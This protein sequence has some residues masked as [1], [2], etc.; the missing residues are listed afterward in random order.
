MGE[1][2]IDAERALIVAQCE[3]RLLNNSNKIAKLRRRVEEQN[4]GLVA[5]RARLTAA[6]R[7]NAAL[8]MTCETALGIVARSDLKGKVP[9]DVIA[10]LTAALAGSADTPATGGDDGNDSR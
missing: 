8:V 7:R 9:R 6:E 2:E 3:R 10:V 5:L 1:A 4:Q